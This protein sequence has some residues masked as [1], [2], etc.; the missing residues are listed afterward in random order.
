MYW[1]SGS[2]TLVH[3]YQPIGVLW[4]L[5][6]LHQVVQDSQARTPQ[7]F[8]FIGSS[9]GV[10]Q[11]PIQVAA[12]VEENASLFNLPKMVGFPPKLLEVYGQQMRNSERL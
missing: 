2:H 3:H 12:S 5:M 6:L 7:L 1:R 8:N 11:A 4:D 9:S 10:S